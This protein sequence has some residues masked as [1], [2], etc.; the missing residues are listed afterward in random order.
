M[1]GPNAKLGLVK[2]WFNRH[3]VRMSRESERDD[4]VEVSEGHTS[5]VVMEVGAALQPGLYALIA[6]LACAK[7][8]HIDRTSYNIDG[9]SWGLWVF[10]DPLRNI[11]V[12]W[13]SP[14]GDNDVLSRILD[15]WN[16]II[17][18]DGARVFR[19]YVIQR[20][21]AHILNEAKYL[22]RTLPG[23]KDA[24]YILE[25]LLKIYSDAK[26]FTGT[27][28]ERVKKRYEFSR[29]IRT[30]VDRFRGDPD[31]DEFMTTLDN[32]AHDLFLFVVHPWVPS[33]N[34]PAEKLLREPV[35]LRKI[36]G[37]LRSLRGVAAFCALM[38]CGVTWKMHGLRPLD[39]IRR[40]L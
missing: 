6:L 3:S 39:E 7:V 10:F 35:V 36:R 12:Y 33:T 37:A 8:I 31:L 18:C 28:D 30:I 34:N 24:L 19:K 22:V 2:N 38:S 40:I 25:R 23:N 32:A 26:E 27:H 17:V 1:F 5:N 13:L 14:D 16:G 11:A 4:G 29:R 9:A 15:A 20:C 21:W